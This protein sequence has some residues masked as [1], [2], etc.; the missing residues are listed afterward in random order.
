MSDDARHEKAKSPM[1]QG[2]W[3]DFQSK[4]LNTSL[5]LQLKGANG[6]KE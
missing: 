3:Q 5:T 2:G 1:E 6:K 4:I